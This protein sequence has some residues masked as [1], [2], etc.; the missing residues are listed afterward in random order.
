[1]LYRPCFQHLYH[2]E[3]KR[4]TMPK[5]Y[6]MRLNRGERPN[7]LPQWVQNKL[8][9]RFRYDA[10][11]VQRYPSYQEFYDRLAE[12]LRL[13]ASW[14]V[15]GAGI[16]EFIR[17]LMM[18]SCDPGQRAMVL[19]PTCAMYDIYAKVFGIELVRLTPSATA[20]DSAALYDPSWI[21]DWIRSDSADLRIVFIPN[22][23]QPI[24]TYFTPAALRAVATACRARDIILVMDEA[25]GGF[26][27]ETALPLV[28]EFDNVLVLRTFSKYFGAASIRVGFAVG[29]PRVITPLNAARPSGEIAGAS[30][31]MAGVLLTCKG[32]FEQEARDTALVRDWLRDEINN[33]TLPILA[34]GRYGFSIR[35]KLEGEFDAVL[36]GEALAKRGILVKYGFPY[37]IADCLLLACG[38]QPMMREFYNQLWDCYARA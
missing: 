37:P 5:Q 11:F 22:P 20:G 26:G 27:A 34:S 29:Q 3:R 4:I 19:W 33:S 7:P 6:K 31:A 35:L 25:H 10:P 14:I 36:L 8:V 9:G 32:L 23:G 16:E 38:N 21:A 13:P 30:M 17:A 1:M 18:L 2:V 15:V 12:E 28:T 24:E